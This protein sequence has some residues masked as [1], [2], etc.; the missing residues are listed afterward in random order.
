[1]TSP[2]TAPPTRPWTSP[3]CALLNDDLQLAQQGLQ[4]TLSG[5]VCERAQRAL[6]HFS[7]EPST[8]TPRIAGQATSLDDA[9]ERAA[10]WLSASRQPLFGGLATDVAG[11]RALYPL[12]CATGAICDAA[13]GAVQLHGLRALQDRGAFVTTLAEVRNRADLIVCIGEAP[14]QGFPNLWRRC[15]IGEPLVALR[16]IVFLGGALDASLDALPGVTQRRVALP[17]DLFDAVA[18]LSALVA[19][20]RVPDAAPA[21]A[22]LAGQ[23]RAARYAVIVWEAAQLPEHGALIAEALNQLVGTLNRSTRAALLPLV[24]NDGLLTVNQ[25]FSWLSGLPLRSRAGPLGLEHE[26]LRF[27]ARRLLADGSVDALLWISSF[28]PEPAPPA[29]TLPTVVLGHPALQAAVAADAVFIPVSTPGMGSA[30]H[31]FRVDGVVALPLDAVYDDGLPTV[32]QVLTRIAARVV[33]RK[34]GEGA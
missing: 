15:G 17:G 18:Q 1:M 12:A 6:R 14:R 34:Q 32:A 27:D 7:A 8:A 10:Q 3:F 16:E 20:R 2:A 21:L 13:A 28:G 9:I 24:G 19:G 5:T 30:G 29:T 11:A 33:A 25:V 23:L 26:P 22:A 31:L 4:F